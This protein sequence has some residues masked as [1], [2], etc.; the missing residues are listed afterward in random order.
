M[1][2]PSGIEP[3][4]NS[5]PYY[6]VDGIQIWHGDARDVM[7]MLP[8][9]DLIV[10]DPPYPNGAGHFLDGIDAARA[11]LTETMAARVFTFWHQLEAPPS[12]LPLV[13][14]HVWHRTNT[15]RP[16]NYEAIYEFAG[17][18]EQ[19]SQVFPYPVIY[20]GLTGCTE[21]NGHPTQKP[22]RLME[23]LITLRKGSGTVLDPFMGSGTTLVAA[24]LLGRPA[25]GIDIDERWCEVAAGRF[26][27]AIFDF[28]EFANAE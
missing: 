10:T 1:T 25:I 28:G 7:P 11:V 22:I 12:R 3:L 4:F 21:A 24:R 14:R 8:P 5:R 19:S 9:V 23:R 18:P 17:G 13:A 26:A 27:Q 20:P 15:N 2:P 6:E 16:D